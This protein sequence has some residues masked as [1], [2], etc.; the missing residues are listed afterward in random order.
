MTPL[1]YRASTIRVRNDNAHNSITLPS[2]VLPTVAFP[3]FLGLVRCNNPI[4]IVHRIDRSNCHVDPA[5]AQAAHHSHW[6][7]GLPSHDEA[8]KHCA[9]R[10]DITVVQQNERKTRRKG[11]A[12]A[13]EN[14]TFKQKRPHE[15]GER[16]PS[17]RHRR[18]HTE[19]LHA[20]YIAAAF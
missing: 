4:L 3:S 15:L 20:S 8:C 6:R 5:R 11:G 2:V 16:A 14:P 17:P 13:D 12:S 1:Q 19:A 7:D 10:W 9:H 18:T